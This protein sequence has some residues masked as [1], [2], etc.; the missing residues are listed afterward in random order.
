[1]HAEDVGN[2]LSLHTSLHRANLCNEAEMRNQKVA[3]ASARRLIEQPEVNMSDL[4]EPVTEQDHVKGASD[5]AV[6]V[7]EYGDFQCPHCA[8]AT[9]VIEELQQNDPNVRF[10]FRHFPLVD[11]HPSAVDAAIAAEC[12]ARQGKFW[13]FYMLLFEN[14]TA[15]DRASIIAYAQDV[16]LDLDQFQSDLEDPSVKD[17]INS[18]L[19]SAANSGVNATPTI[20]I[21][22]QRY[23]GPHSFNELSLVIRDFEREAS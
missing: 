13:E 7:V 20:F 2:K 4:K 17:K 9:Q 22:S 19:A 23:E 11:A 12:A 14:P 16:G 1:M 15:L 18:D 6:T 21:N 10:A 8:E 3:V 5:A